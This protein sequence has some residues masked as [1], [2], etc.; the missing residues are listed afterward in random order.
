MQERDH[1]MEERFSTALQKGMDVY[2]VNGDKIGKV[3]KIYQPAAVSSTAST[4]A[5]PASRSYLKVDTGFLGLGKDL[6]IPADAVR[7]V[8]GDRVTLTTDKDRLDAMGWDHRPDWLRD[9]H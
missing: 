8:N 7:D 2:D 5:E 3:G 9:E 1:L 6:Y 4:H